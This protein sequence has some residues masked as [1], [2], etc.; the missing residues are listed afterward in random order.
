MPFN[1]GF[2][3]RSIP[4]VDPVQN[5]ASMLISNPDGSGWIPA[6]IEEQVVSASINIHYQAEVTSSGNIQ[7][8]GLSGSEITLK[9]NINLTSVTASFNGNLAGTA[10]YATDAG[11]A[12]TASYIATASYATNAGN[13]NTASYV[14]TAQTASYVTASSIVNFTNDVRTQISAGTNLTYSVGQISL[15][16]DPSVTNLTA[17]AAYV[18]NNLKVDGTINVSGNI[19]PTVSSSSTLGTLQYPFKEI[20]VGSGSISIQSSISG[21][22][23]TTISNNAGNLEI[24]A[25]GIKLIGTGSFITTTGSFQYVSGNVSWVGDNNTYG[26]ISASGGFTGSLLGTASYAT[27]A[28]TAQTASYV[29]AS[30][31]AGLTAAIQ[32]VAGSSSTGSWTPEFTITSSLAGASGSYIIVQSGSGKYIKNGSSVTAI[33]SVRI[34][35]VTG[36]FTDNAIMDVSSIKLLGLPFTASHEIGFRNS[37]LNNFEG[38]N[39]GVQGLTIP[40]ATSA[41]LY[42][43]KGDAPPVV[44]TGKVFKRTNRFNTK[45]NVIEDALTGSRCDFTIT[46]FTNS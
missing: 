16:Q 36:N 37:V 31:V 10:S 26:Y 32:A 30:N 14:E 29:T 27:N 19:V 18:Q 17:S 13:A 41:S 45:T 3:E 46:Y 8:N 25:G 43:G 40:T 28:G 24:S 4:W 2:R 11:N 9:D 39:D 7:G 12:S 5:T 38:G 1:D 15:V 20:F 44:L 42:T 33:G 6:S 34:S 35:A 22:I 23:P 21:T